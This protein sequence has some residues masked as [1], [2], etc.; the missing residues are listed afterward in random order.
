MFFL[1][2]EP[3]TD[4]DVSG[5]FLPARQ[6]KQTQESVLWMSAYPYGEPSRVK[7]PR[8]FFLNDG[9]VV[10]EEMH[11]RIYG[12]AVANDLGWKRTARL[13]CSAIVVGC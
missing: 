7:P 6:S 10:I 12:R 9:R 1:N 8:I 11:A 2:L 13:S 4:I 5:F 3:G